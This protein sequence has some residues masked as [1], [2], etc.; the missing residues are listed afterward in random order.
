MVIKR[1]QMH[2]RELRFNIPACFWLIRLVSVLMAASPR[3][4]AVA[5][6]LI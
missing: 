6:L 4:F 1:L 5:A 2:R 3:G